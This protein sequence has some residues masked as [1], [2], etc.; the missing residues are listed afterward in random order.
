MPGGTEGKGQKDKGAAMRRI[1]ERKKHDKLR[2]LRSTRRA[3]SSFLYLKNKHFIKMGWTA[4]QDFLPTI[5]DEYRFS[6]TWDF[7]DCSGDGI[8][9][10]CFAGYPGYST[11]IFLLNSHIYDLQSI[12]PAVNSLFSASKLSH[13]PLSV[14]DAGSRGLSFAMP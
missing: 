7:N 3:A 1:E 14:L 9:L 5:D 12:E 13:L 8:S 4:W 10:I 2:S 6:C 11:D